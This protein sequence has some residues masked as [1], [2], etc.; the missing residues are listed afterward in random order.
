MWVEHSFSLWL[1]Q[2]FSSLM[3][4]PRHPSVACSYTYLGEGGAQGGAGEVEGGA[5]GGAGGR[6]GGS[7]A[8]LKWQVEPTERWSSPLFD[9]KPMPLVLA[10]GTV[11]GYKRVTKINDD[12]FQ[13][14]RRV[15]GKLRHVWT[16]DYVYNPWE[17][18]RVF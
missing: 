3:V 15:N 14:R 13:A 8:M 18:T 7:A 4:M 11:S 16:S 12:T 1:R 9:G 10:P 5:Q 2:P 6:S 17:R